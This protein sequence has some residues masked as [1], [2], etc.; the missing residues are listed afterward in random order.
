MSCSTCRHYRGSCSGKGGYVQSHVGVDVKYVE[1]GSE[2]YCTS[3]YHQIMEIE[4]YI[5]HTGPQAYA[6]Y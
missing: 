3:D 4:R 6:A 2:A 5:I 1:E